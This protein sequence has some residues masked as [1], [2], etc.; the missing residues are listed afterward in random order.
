MSERNVKSS[1]DDKKCDHNYKYHE[2]RGGFEY[3]YYECT[4]CGDYYKLYYEDMQ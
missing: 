2:E 3:E 4:K 1:T